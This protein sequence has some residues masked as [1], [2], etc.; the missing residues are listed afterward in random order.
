MKSYLVYIPF[1]FQIPGTISEVSEDE[2]NCDN[3]DD[4]DDICFEMDD[5]DES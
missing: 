4:D 5:D 3:N 2:D 1:L